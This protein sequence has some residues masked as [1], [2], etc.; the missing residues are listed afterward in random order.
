MDNIK[1]YN[2]FNNMGPG[3]ILYNE[4]I[5]SKSFIKGLK[6]PVASYTLFD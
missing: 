6:V 1:V 3:L 2:K 5:C 4:I